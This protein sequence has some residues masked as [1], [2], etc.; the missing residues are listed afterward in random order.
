MSLKV[1]PKKETSPG[2]MGST[3]KKVVTFSDPGQQQQFIV[4]SSKES[5][6]Q[7]LTKLKLAAREFM[8]VQSKKKG[9]EA[10]N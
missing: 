10:T 4:M 6:L 7:T 3:N 2:T 5:L 8:T 9:F 1:P